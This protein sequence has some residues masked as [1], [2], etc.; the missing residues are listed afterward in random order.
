MPYNSYNLYPSQ[1]TLTPG[2]AGKT[3]GGHFGQS[4]TAG[5]KS[6]QVRVSYLYFLDLEVIKITQRNGFRSEIWRELSK[7][8]KLQFK[9]VYMLKISETCILWSLLEGGSCA[10]RIPK[11]QIFVLSFHR[12]RMWIKMEELYFWATFR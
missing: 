9:Q 2:E 6:S 8:Y 5:E 12:C 10:L 3:G 7:K 1:Q 4:W 11:P